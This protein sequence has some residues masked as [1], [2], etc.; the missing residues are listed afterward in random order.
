MLPAASNLDPTCPTCASCLQY[1]SNNGYIVPGKGTRPVVA[2]EDVANAT[3]LNGTNATNATAVNTTFP[4]YKANRSGWRPVAH[5][6]F[7]EVVVPSNG[8]RRIQLLE[9][10]TIP[11]GESELLLPIEVNPTR[12]TVDGNAPPRVLALRSG[13][14]DGEY[15]AGHTINVTVLFTTAVDWRPEGVADG[16][17]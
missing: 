9:E 15:G 5:A 7:Q 17:K 2:V 3:L 1:G 12:L 6:A 8:R 11:D 14:E 10:F 4:P 16:D 13:A